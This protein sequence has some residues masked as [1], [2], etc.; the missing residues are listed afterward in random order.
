MTSPINIPHLMERAARLKSPASR[1]NRKYA[2]VCLCQYLGADEL[3]AASLTKE[4]I[5]G[6]LTWLVNNGKST[7][8]IELYRKELRSAITAEYPALA[9]LAKEAF[10]RPRS[11]WNSRKE[12]LDVEMMRR[13]ARAE[14]G[15]MTPWTQSRDAYL[16]AF[17][18]GGLSYDEL[19][20]LGHDALDGDYLR[21][22]GLR[23][24]RLNANLR[25]LI[26]NYQ[27]S[28]VPAL[29]PFLQL[30][31]EPQLR[32]NL[33]RIG[34]KLALAGLD[35]AKGAA[36][37]WITVAKELGVDPAVMAAVAEERL[38]ILSNY[39]D[40][41][42][43]DRAAIDLATNRVSTAVADDSEHW[44][45]M[46]LRR[47]C[48]P[49]DVYATLYANKRYPHLRTP[50]TYYPCDDVTRHV[51]KRLTQTSRAYIA[52]VLFFRT[53]PH[54]VPLIASIVGEVAWIYR[55]VNDTN[56]PYA[57]IPQREMA[58]F[59]A[60][61]AHFTPDI[62]VSFVRQD[63]VIVGRRVRITGGQFA[64]CEGIIADTRDDN[65][66][67]LRELIISFT[68]MNSMRIRANISEADVEM[69]G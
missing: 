49:E 55:H 64:G 5:D 68:A 19:R 9:E 12:G 1:R 37:S 42:S 36:K 35:D 51:G 43:I 4:T 33:V 7:G 63:E 13:L 8:T 6:Y 52:D 59:Q 56:S 11:K 41:A 21:L 53:K 34:R 29:L 47:Q 38:G 65:Y 61:V 32:A 14:F 67:E 22:P 2:L 23:R 10:A 58:N 60:A 50:V 27:A 57:I 15:G 3:A 69:V 62:D 40:E 24:V 28:D 26:A 20:S 16:L 54:N 17:Y 39:S 66:S 25:T 18:C 31:S 44:Y 48:V 45:A 30:M 46:K